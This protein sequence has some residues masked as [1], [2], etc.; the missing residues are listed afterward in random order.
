MAQ[1]AMLAGVFKLL[2]VAVQ[3]ETDCFI[4]PGVRVAEVELALE[5]IYLKSDSEKMMDVCFT[6]QVKS[7]EIVDLSIIIKPEVS[8]VKI[9]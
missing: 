7:E 1:R 4:M 3:E 9:G 8:S 2:G 6:N 5:D